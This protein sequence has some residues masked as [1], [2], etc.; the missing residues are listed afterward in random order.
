MQI[1]LRYFASLREYIG[2][3]EQVI[4]AD[5]GITIRELWVLANPDLIFPNNTLV[6]KNL[7]YVA[8]TEGGHEGDEIAFFPPVTGG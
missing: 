5:V 3:S 7:E 2:R 8:L 6:A 1:K 4:E